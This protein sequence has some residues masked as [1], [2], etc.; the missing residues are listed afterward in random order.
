MPEV[1]EGELMVFYVALT[2]AQNH[3][4]II[5][6]AKEKDFTFEEIEKQNNYLKLI[7]FALGENFT[8]QLFSQSE[9]KT[10]NL[11]QHFQKKCYG[12]G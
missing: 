2:R 5:G 7:M 10:N 8:S 11:T 1:I 4:Y 12:G 6:S 3:L 9:I